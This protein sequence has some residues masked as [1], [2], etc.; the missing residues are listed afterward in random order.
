MISEWMDHGNI[1][2]FVEKHDGINR[3]QLV[4]YGIALWVNEFN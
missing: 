4:S 3:V 2:E 1:N